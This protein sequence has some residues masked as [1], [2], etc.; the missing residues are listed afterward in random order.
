MFRV[1][2]MGFTLLFT[3]T[4]GEDGEYIADEF[5]RQLFKSPYM[6]CIYATHFDKLKKIAQE[7]DSNC[8]NYKIG[9]PTKDEAG[10]LHYPYTFGKGV[11]NVRV[12]IHM[13]KMKG[14]I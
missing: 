6:L 8:A 10:K 12:G 2:T 11:N 3:G 13:A 7:K 5:I 9:A 14:L 4:A 1:L